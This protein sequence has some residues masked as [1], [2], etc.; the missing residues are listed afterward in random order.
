MYLKLIEEN[1]LPES[2]IK[3]LYS[4]ENSS[5]DLRLSDIGISY[6]NANLFNPNI[7]YSFDNNFETDETKNPPEQKYE[8]ELN[9]F[10]QKSIRDSNIAIKNNFENNIDKNNETKSLNNILENEEDFSG[11]INMLIKDTQITNSSPNKNNRKRGREKSLNS[12]KKFIHSSLFPDNLLAKIQIHFFSF[13]IDI[14]NDALFTGLGHDINY[15]FKEINYSLKRKINYDYFINLFNYNIRN[16]LQM[17]IS[18]KY[19]NFNRNHNA[20]TVNQ[21]C[22]IS[23]WLDKFFNTS[24]LRMFK[25]YYNRKM[26]LNGISFEGKY[27]KF[28][29]KTKTFYDL[30]VKRN[31]ERN[32]LISIAKSYYLNGDDGERHISL[33]PLHKEL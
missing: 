30:L 28:S 7:V 25:Y 18:S 21:V 23:P 9:S 24:Y 11:D 17:D 26:P 15:S 13:L 2:D 3:S 31:H 4:E 33:L 27:I 19:R 1:E 14:S 16:I 5:D 10:K 22:R 32:E 29:Y 20:E 8:S 12:N 6:I